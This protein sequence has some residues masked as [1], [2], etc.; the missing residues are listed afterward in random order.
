MPAAL[1]LGC[2]IGSRASFRSFFR[3]VPS[4]AFPKSHLQKSGLNPPRWPHSGI[5][6]ICHPDGDD[7]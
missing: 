3:R 2:Q 4:P 6:G 5:A 7:G 1:L